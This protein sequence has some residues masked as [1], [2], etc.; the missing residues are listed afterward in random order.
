MEKFA[1]DLVNDERIQCKEDIVVSNKKTRFLALQTSS[2][3]R[4]S[5]EQPLVSDF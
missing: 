1:R 3:W 2:S 4:R 5:Y